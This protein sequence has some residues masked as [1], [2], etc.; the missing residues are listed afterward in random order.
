[1]LVRVETPEDRFSGVA[2]YLYVCFSR[3][4]QHGR[5]L[6][7]VQ[8]F[9]KDAPMKATPE[10][11]PAHVHEKPIRKL[12]FSLPVPK[13]STRDIFVNKTE[14][15]DESFYMPPNRQRRE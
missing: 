5:I 1:M 8:Q 9:T 4:E 13:F 10:P 14:D 11:P 7:E 2:A 12:G 6:S 15:M 3:V